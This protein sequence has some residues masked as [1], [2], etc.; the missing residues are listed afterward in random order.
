MQAIKLNINHKVDGI[1]E[2]DV[3]K[4][5]EFDDTILFVLNIR[6]IHELSIGQKLKFRRRLYR[7]DGQYKFLD[8]EVEIVDLYQ[9][10]DDNGIEY[11]AIETSQ[12]IK[13]YLEID[14]QTIV[15]STYYDFSGGTYFSSITPT[16][17]ILDY[18]HVDETELDYYYSVA[19][20]LTPSEYDLYDYKYLVVTGETESGVKH[21]DIVYHQENMIPPEYDFYDSPYLSGMS[22]DESVDE[23][24]Q[25]H[26]DEF[27]YFSGMTHG[28]TIAEYIDENPELF[29]FDEHIERYIVTFTRNHDI[30]YQDIK[31]INETSGVAEYDIAV[32]NEYTDVI[33]YLSGLQILHRLSDI[34]VEDEDFYTTTTEETCGIYDGNGNPYDIGIN[35]YFF[36][37]NDISFNRIAVTN[38]STSRV[39]RTITDTDRTYR[40]RQIEYLLNNGVYFVPRYNPFY[41]TYYDVNGKNG[42]FWGDVLWDYYNENNDETP[43]TEIWINCGSTQS[44]LTLDESYY[45]IPIS[46][47]SDDNLGLGSEDSFDD[48]VDETIDSLIP[49]TIDYERVKYV[50]IDY[51]DKSNYMRVN[52]IILNFHFRK[53]ELIPHSTGTVLQYPIYDDGW[54]INSDS[55]ATVWWNEMNYYGAEFD[56]GSMITFIREQSAYT[57]NAKSDLLGY[58]DFKDE[59]VYNQ[60]KKIKETFV[61]LSFYTSKDPIEQKL[62]YYSTVFL[63]SNTLFG[64]YMKQK[65][66]RYEQDLHP[67]YPIVFE[68]D[69]ERLDSRIVITSENDLTSSSE[70]FNLYLFK[71]DVDET[72]ARTIYMKVEFNHAKFGKT[73]PMI[74]WPIDERTKR[75]LPLTIENYLDSLYIPITLRFLNGS[76]T[77]EINGVRYDYMKNQLSDTINLM[78]FEPKID[79]DVIQG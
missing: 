24:V 43:T 58:L 2:L 17:S 29:E 63:N 61:R 42:V 33:G 52:K 51:L 15:T 32:L 13:P 8:Y 75:F 79:L 25:Q 21:V 41:Y 68:Q 67:G 76:M 5:F 53:R 10:T 6:I 74:M 14:R 57:P 26:P 23:F 38:G 72:S 71:D 69:Y 22:Q 66:R 37:P 70:G 27:P 59:D 77:Y 44:V 9:Y 54:Y 11:D 65:L 46:P 47:L 30:F 35:N 50:P 36:V 64:K 78:L 20:A 62:L 40:N 12:V 49:D 39:Q 45:S 18:I 3:R 4:F 60:K 1:K 7:Q 34:I 16:V 31:L 56:S 48:Y 19:S 55:G 28:Q 73:I